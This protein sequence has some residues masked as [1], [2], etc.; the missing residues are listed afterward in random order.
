VKLRRELVVNRLS[1]GRSGV[2]RRR[3]CEADVE[4]RAVGKR[5]DL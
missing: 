4:V 1:D 3:V 5:M 2:L